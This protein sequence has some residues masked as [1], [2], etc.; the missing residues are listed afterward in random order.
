MT[1]EMN[2]AE[3]DMK[4]VLKI[5]MAEAGVDSLADTARSLNI[6]ET[7][8]RSAVANNSLRVADFMKVAEF[9]GYEVIVRSKDSNLS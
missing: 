4:R 9:M 5:M 6:K 8:F 2:L 3:T 1:R 7:T